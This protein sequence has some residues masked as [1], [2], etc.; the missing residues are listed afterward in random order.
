MSEDITR[1]RVGFVIGG[2]QKSGTTALAQYLS[3]HPQVAMPAGKEAHV[4]D[5]P[6]FDE[7]WSVSEVDSRYAPHYA[8]A[9]PGD[10]RLFGDATPIYMLHPAFVARIRRYNP[11][12]RWIVL[13]RD[14]VDRALSQFHME[15]GRGHEAY[16]FWLALLL[17]RWRL[18]GHM[19]DFSDASPLR[20]HSYR[21]RGDYAPQI[22]RLR[23]AFTPERLLIVR[24]ADLRRDPA[25]VV[26][27]VC[28]FLDLED[29]PAGLAYSGVFEGKYA[30]WGDSDWR[31]ALLGLWWRRERRA[32]RRLDGESAQPGAR[33]GGPHGNN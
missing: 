1:P 5:A 26:G 18:A 33:E 23:Q 27:R 24:N 25:G 11:E 30:R 17:E 2:A 12:M 32:M 29:M 16:P 8:E 14:P 10:G 3:R 28:R 21:L 15:R 9:S 22:E 13:L 20:H 6:D 19:A 4:F 7:A 31:R